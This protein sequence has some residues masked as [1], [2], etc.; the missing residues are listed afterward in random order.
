MQDVDHGYILIFCPTGT[1]WAERH[2]TYLILAKRYI[3]AAGNHYEGT[4]AALEGE[5]LASVGPKAKLEITARGPLIEVRLNGDKVL[6]ARDDTSATGRI[7]LRTAG[8][9]EVPSDATYSKLTIH[10]NTKL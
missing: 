8:D 9:A 4:L 7:G 6:E 1:T 5:K 10:E 3:D 2:P